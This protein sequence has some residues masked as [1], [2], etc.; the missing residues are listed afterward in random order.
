[1]KNFN[2]KTILTSAAIILNTALLI[3]CVPVKEKPQPQIPVKKATVSIIE[4]SA[5][6]QKNW[7]DV[8]ALKDEY[9]KYCKQVTALRKSSD[10]FPIC[11]IRVVYQ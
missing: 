5:A 7:M 10:F 9:K 8:P 2:P 4:E 1:M 3:S 11:Y 6:D